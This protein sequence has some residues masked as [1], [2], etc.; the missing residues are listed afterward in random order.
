MI[1]I[2][3]I[4]R[5][6]MMMLKIVMFVVRMIIMVVGIRIAIMMYM[7]VMN[8]MCMCAPSGGEGIG[9]LLGVETDPMCV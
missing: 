4:M 9:C 1:K 7:C 3:M 8:T 6:M 5:V 2:I